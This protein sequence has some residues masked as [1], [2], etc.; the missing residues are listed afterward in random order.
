MRWTWLSCALGR[1][2]NITCNSCRVHIICTKWP[3]DALVRQ[4]AHTR[5]E[6]EAG[7]QLSRS[8]LKK[9]ASAD[10]SCLWARLSGMGYRIWRYCIYWKSEGSH[11]REKSFFPF[12]VCSCYWQKQS[13]EGKD[14]VAP[15]GL[16][17]SE[18]LIPWAG[19]YCVQNLREGTGP[20]YL[21]PLSYGHSITQLSIIVMGGK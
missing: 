6:S 14:W 15:C 3:A 11:S 1:M 2:A 8:T 21:H 19:S 9:R 7:G 17:T 20:S 12:Y 10:K 13:S 5:S 4:E 16:L 18:V